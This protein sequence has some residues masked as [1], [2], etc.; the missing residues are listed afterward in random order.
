MA[1]E[2]ECSPLNSEGVRGSGQAF[3]L[4]RH[5]GTFPQSQRPVW[6]LPGVA[7]GECL[8]WKCKCICEF[9]QGP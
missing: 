2:V 6:S 4:C 8:K 3:G 1:E 5:L 7:T 9:D